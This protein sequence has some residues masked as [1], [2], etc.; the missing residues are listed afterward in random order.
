MTNIENNYRQTIKK[1]N[2]IF[3]LSLITNSYLFYCNLEDD[4]INK[5]VMMYNRVKENKMKLISDDY[6][7]S[8]SLYFSLATNRSIYITPTLKEIYE[9]EL[10]QDQ[11]V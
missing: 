1:P 7:A 2:G 6:F 4:N 11:I 3:T 9:K 10:V 8:E 5:N